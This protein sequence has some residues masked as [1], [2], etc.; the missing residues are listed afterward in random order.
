[1]TDDSIDP[2]V[3][4]P[5]FWDAL[6]Y[7]SF[8]IDLSKY[9]AD[10]QTLFH[11]LEVMLPCSHCRRHY[12]VYKKQVPPVSNIKKEEKYS[13]AMWLWIIHDM[14]NQNLG[15]V[16]IS[17]EKLEKKHTSLT[18]ITSDFIIFDIVVFMWMSS[19][20]NVK[21]Y[22]GITIFLNLLYTIRKFKVCEVLKDKVNDG[23]TFEMIHEYKNNMLL[24]YEYPPITFED[25][26]KSYKNSIAI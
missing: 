13:A 9:Y 1:M 25:M 11:L 17:Y 20:K 21:V 14:V 5:S 24:L 10:V 19:K 7:I 8:N 2:N 12:S 18:C 15:K 26:V 23:L 22:N 6:F 3:W 4:G 16:C